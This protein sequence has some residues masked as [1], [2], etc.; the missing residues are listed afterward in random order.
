MADWLKQSGSM[1]V[2]HGIHWAVLIN[3]P[4]YEELDLLLQ[5]E[6]K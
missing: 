1:F 2:F 4:K 5:N 6:L 3:Y